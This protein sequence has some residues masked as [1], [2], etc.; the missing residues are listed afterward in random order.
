M[1]IKRRR[2]F[3]PDRHGPERRNYEEMMGLTAFFDVWVAEW[4]RFLSLAAPE[5]AMEVY[6]QP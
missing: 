5:M 4:E 3:R 6:R 1:K 2:R